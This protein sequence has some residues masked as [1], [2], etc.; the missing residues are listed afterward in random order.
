[1][2]SLKF[3]ITGD[4]KNVLDSFNGVQQGVR[5]MQHE[6]EHSGQSIE[7]MFN[8][9][10]YAATASLAGFSVK[11]FVH[12][13]AQVR[14]EFQQ[15]EVAFTTMLGSAE[16]AKELMQQLTRTAARTPFDLQS[17]ANGAK[18]LMAYGVAADQVNDILV[19]LGDIAAGLSIPLND[20]VMLY[21]TTMTQ[22]RMFTQDLRQF[23]GRGIPLADELAKQFGVTKDKVGELVTAGKVGAEEFNKAIMSMSSEGGKFAGL[24]EAQSE[25]ISGQISNIED[26]IDVMFNNI[27]KS[28]EGIIN[29]VL[30]SVSSLV[31]NYEKVG[32]VLMGAVIA[33]GT[34]K[35][36]LITANAIEKA[37][38]SIKQAMAVQ[39][40]LLAAEAR[41]LAAARGISIAAAKAELGSV[42]VLTVA[43]MRLT[44]ATKALTASMMDNPYTA[45]AAALAVVA[46]GVYKLATAEG[47]ETAARRK[48]NE[49]MQTFA[50]KLDEQQNK[51]KDYIQT[52]QDETAT[53]YQKAVAWEMLNK[54][55][56]TLTEKYDKAAMATLDLAE[57]TKELNEQA[58]EA[59]YE[60]IR[61]E[62][63]KWKETIDRIK[64]NMLNDARYTGGKNAI[65]N[66]MQLED[67]E[68][69]LDQYLKK[70]VEIE[71]IR[72]KIAEDNKPLE[73]RIKEANENVQAKQEIYDFYK[74][75]A[76]LAGELKN[77]HDEA[78]GVIANSGI[79][80]NYEAIADQTKEKYDALIA[81]LEADVEDLRTRIA[82]S[83]ASLELEQEL[84]GKEKALN[85]L[86]AM[87]QQ[88]AL[89]GV[90][91]I[92]LQF[93]LNFSQVETALQNAKNGQGINT[94]GMRFNGPTGTWVKDEATAPETHTAAQWRRDAYNN[95]KR[96]QA[97]VDAFWQK[98]ESMDK[99]TFDKQFKKLKDAADQAKK[100]YDKLKGNGG[101]KKVAQ[102]AKQLQDQWKHEEQMES[103]ME[104]A[105]R[106]QEDA[107][108]AAIANRS[109]RE[110]EERE[111]QHRRTM[112]D[113][114][115]QR[116]EIFK[117][118]YQQRKE[119]YKSKHN[120]K[121]SLEYELTP[122][123]KA[124]WK[125]IADEWKALS[126]KS[127]DEVKG[128]EFEIIKASEVSTETLQKLNDLSSKGNV[129]LI[130]RPFID[131]A[132]LV[133]KGWKDAGEG[134]ATVFSSSYNVLD[135]KGEAHEILVTPILPDGE[136][137]SE[138]KLRD[139]I[140]KAING[141]EDILSAD[142]EGVVIAVDIEGNEGEALHKLQEQLI[143][144]PTD[145]IEEIKK[146]YKSL[147]HFSKDEQSQYDLWM[148]TI[149]AKQTEASKKRKRE[150]DEE[151][152]ATKKVLRDS[153][154][155]SGSF[156]QQQLA[157]FDEY[158]AKID[159]LDPALDKEQIEILEKERED[160]LASKRAED[161]L[162][163]NDWSGLF[164]GIGNQFKEE[165]KASLDEITEYM[166]SQEFAN[167][168]Q[169]Q[170]NE[171]YRVKGELNDKVGKGEMPFDFSKL[172]TA[173]EQLRLAWKEL[174]T[175]SNKHKIAVDARKRAEQN[176]EEAQDK[177]NN[178]T[179]KNKD[180]LEE[181]V[182]RKKEALELARKLEESTGESLL[183]AQ[184]KTE[185]S[186]NDFVD[187]TQRSI[188][189]INN[190]S[191]SLGE[192]TNG[193]LF[194]FVNG[195]Y[196]LVNSFSSAEGA[197]DKVANGISGAGVWG[198]IIAAI[199]QLIDT[200][201]DDL[202][203]F[204]REL[205][206]KVSNLVEGVLTDL[207]PDLI[208]SIINGIGDLLRGV[209][210]G[211][212]NLLGSIVGFPDLNLFSRGETREEMLERLRETLEDNTHA[213]EKS[214]EALEKQYQ[215]E[216]ERNRNRQ[217]AIDFYNKSVNDARASIE[218]LA[219][220]TS[221]GHHSWWYERNKEWKKESKKEGSNW[222]SIINETL[223]R[224]GFSERV[225]GDGM[226]TLMGLSP[227]A[228]K[229][230]REHSGI[231]SQIF[232]GVNANNAKNGDVKKAFEDL[233]EFADGLKEIEEKYQEG[234]TNISFDSMR[235]NLR[236]AFLDM[237]SDTKD[238]TKDFENDFRDMMASIM[239][240]EW[241]N[242]AETQKKLKEYY[243]LLAEY[244][245][246]GLTK[247]ERA[248]LKR[249]YDEIEE[250][251]LRERN[252][253]KDALG[254]ED[255]AKQQSATANSIANISYD[256]ADALEGILLNHTIL[257]EQGNVIREQIV[258]FL[259][260][261][262]SIHTS[263]INEVR[264]LLI[265]GN[266]TRDN[267]LRSMKLF[268]ENFDIQVE[269]VIT[270]I[271]NS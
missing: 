132:E 106:A 34:Y 36:A 155:Q 82:E 38:I 39:E 128:K 169:P 57:A 68:T 219:G 237:K 7:S 50:D 47:V 74:R 52:I 134:I 87:K 175:A 241:F 88:W 96:A 135:S 170:K 3:D 161:I 98:K 43:K 211:V 262:Q 164:D 192:L 28:N 235:D 205:L 213:L 130:S 216:E 252:K 27:G 67:A 86:I 69:Q 257:F 76:D 48:A 163:R 71:R 194:G 268:F 151:L 250:E 79:P 271:K 138:R 182:K 218:A 196:R 17:V 123:G 103:L 263:G 26:A 131:A 168:P 59:N 37:S 139:Y 101:S 188:S 56:P 258:M 215:T 172:N 191:Q 160:K 245:K 122:E 269:R 156:F 249:R 197:M 83:P 267:I 97:A 30:G 16:K 228:L 186:K 35:T 20:L 195:I 12:K 32:E 266:S 92:P 233:T 117:K 114:E 85:D 107:S 129:D 72:K 189:S 238:F 150:R 225:S 171:F 224:Y 261:L 94:Q 202:P 157:I 239:I 73:I 127:L 247:E 180:V 54:M 231:W 217:E 204:I 75:A 248:E 251:G 91:T 13:V 90:T 99:A 207:I 64:Q 159:Q 112:E 104:N 44:A 61:D 270:Q 143:G 108:I 133:K 174:I 109:R 158:Q 201:G 141:A 190:F 148:K 187:S 236:S 264:N 49:E 153:I 78:A 60:H 144:L 1:M 31:E 223:A 14:G 142:K 167:L 22:G 46:V 89:S 4:N 80:Y 102:R 200:I 234:M 254:Y 81:E 118:I 126:A 260:T 166:K 95:W 105:Q 51:I 93:T 5:R 2:P 203:G 41:N 18:Q 185:Q 256:Q 65:F 146:L 227:E 113:L 6:V 29:D 181:D 100:D 212:V 84:K 240:D 253:T 246:D 179:D 184:N 63:Q 154:M 120:D 243:E 116:D 232:N 42:N 152:K 25:T 111:K 136:V 8:R 121:D 193:T 221:G 58:D 70:L 15:L 173:A 66:L 40:A 229:V 21:G 124:G 140:N 255:E 230:V 53:E 162:G 137:W 55:A 24:M 9:I 222:V 259:Q 45:V 119:A 242:S 226:Q 176:L 62:V 210:N 220:N 265:E 125:G 115:K 19:H 208:P 198:A 206:M 11:E 165:M 23:M 199:L 77:A 147:G 145:K 33:I 177:L 183:V 244:S 209:V 214:T 110:R 10:Q 178:A 149:D